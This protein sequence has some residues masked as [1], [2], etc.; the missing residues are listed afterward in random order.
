M[1]GE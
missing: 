1:K